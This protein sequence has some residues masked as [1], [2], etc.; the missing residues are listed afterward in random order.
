MDLSGGYAGVGVAE[1]RAHRTVIRSLALLA[2]VGVDGEYFL[3]VAD[4]AV[5][6][7]GLARTAGIAQVGDDFVSHD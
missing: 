6:T 7:F 5:R 1:L 2:L 4:R 3:N